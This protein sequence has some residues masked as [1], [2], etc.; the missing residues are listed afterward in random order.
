MNTSDRLK[1]LRN[2]LGISMREVEE[3]SRRIAEA[4]GNSEYIISSAW[5]TQIENSGSTP[6]IYKLFTLSIVY[7]LK[8]T[9]LLNLYG[10]DLERI[11]R[12]QAANPLTSTHLAD[13]TVY[14]ES[15]AIQFPVR[16]D[17]GFKM[18]RT[19]LIA[20]MVEVWGEIPIGILQH[21]DLRKYNYG[22]I[23]TKDFTLHPLL[24]P[25]SFVQID[26]SQT[27]VEKP[28]WKTE[29]D[30]PIYFVE[31]RDKYV[32]S[33][34]EL[35]G[36]QLFIVPHPLSGSAISQYPF[37]DEAEIVGRV[38][39]IAMRIASVQEAPKDLKQLQPVS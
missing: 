31:L 38:T 39:G 2:R 14:D 25:G 34:C 21:L 30:R 22:F 23:G 18:E 1:D 37:P 16:F 29:F 12:L 15:R 8:F 35:H 5:L 7:R 6:S 11:L 13:T 33:W 28:P 3:T 36:K 9:D 27:R 4:Q 10:I 19:G 26:N 24:R 32:C 20:R 17:K